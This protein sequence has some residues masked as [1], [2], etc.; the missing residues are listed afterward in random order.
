MVH[1]P[2]SDLGL[3]VGSPANCRAKLTLK[4]SAV[5]EG[6]RSASTGKPV[7]MRSVDSVDSM[8][9]SHSGRSSW[10]T[11]PMSSATRARRNWQRAMQVCAGNPYCPF[12]IEKSA[13]IC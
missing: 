5:S 4:A 13:E 11:V 12:T 9:S 2:Y 1:I 8:G 6:G 7:G 10:A 3:N